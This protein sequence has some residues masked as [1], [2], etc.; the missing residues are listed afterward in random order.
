MHHGGSSYRRQTF[1]SETE[2]FFNVRDF[3]AAAHWAIE[4]LGVML[5]RDDVEGCA[6]A[7]TSRS[8]G[9]R[10]QPMTAADL[11][12]FDPRRFADIPELY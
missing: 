8:D 10:P 3:T 2:S 6:S 9:Q 7:K 5:S 4:R 12:C 11:G 1:A